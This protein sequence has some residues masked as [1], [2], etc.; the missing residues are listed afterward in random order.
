MNIFSLQDKVITDYQSY[1]TSFFSSFL[2]YD[3]S[4]MRFMDRFLDEGVYEPELIFKNATQAERLKSH[5]GVLWKLQN[6][7]KY[8]GLANP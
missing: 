1:V 7:R 2:Q 5:P 3:E 6:H 4:E 8:L